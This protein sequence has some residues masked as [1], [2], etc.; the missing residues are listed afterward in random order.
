M[1]YIRLYFRIVLEKEFSDRVQNK[2][3]VPW[4]SPIYEETAL[5]RSTESQVNRGTPIRKYLTKVLNRYFKYQKKKTPYFVYHRNK[6]SLRDGTPKEGPQSRLR[7]SDTRK[8]VFERPRPTTALPPSR[9]NRS[10]RK[11]LSQVEAENL[12]KPRPEDPRV[13]DCSTVSLYIPKGESCTKTP[14]SEYTIRDGTLSISD[15][16]CLV[17]GDKMLFRE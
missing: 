9:T 5:R 17:E 2:K 15:Q 12:H 7:T 6:C 10:D 4:T 3:K 13:H 1:V 14:G 11:G 8:P 16:L